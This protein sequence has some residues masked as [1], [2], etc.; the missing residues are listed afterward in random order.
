MLDA[1]ADLALAGVVDPGPETPWDQRLSGILAAAR[2]AALQHPGIAAHIAARPPLGVHGLRLAAGITAS[3]TEAGLS[4]TAVVQTL[5]TLIAYVTAALAMAV[6]AGV[7]D[8][9]WHRVSQAMSGLP[10]ETLPIV[11]SSEQFTYGLRL[12]LHGIRAEAAAGGSR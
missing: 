3:L 12:L 2:S 5:Q 7:R 4:P 1:V 10:G 6:N 8:E 9:R 11:G